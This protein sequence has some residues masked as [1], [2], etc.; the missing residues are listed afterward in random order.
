M[1]LGTQIKS[2]KNLVKIRQA[3]ASYYVIL[4]KVK[5]KAI[6]KIKV[7]IKAKVMGMLVVLGR[8]FRT[9][10]TLMVRV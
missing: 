8:D 10:Y 7:K 2:P 4:L 6:I 3:G 1:V 9:S 5:V